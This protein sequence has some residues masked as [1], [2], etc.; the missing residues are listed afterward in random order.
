MQKPLPGISTKK[1]GVWSYMKAHPWLYLLMLPGLIYLIIFNYMPL[2]GIAIAFQNFNFVKG[3][4]GSQWI[5]LKNFQELFRS[6]QFLRV[7]RNSLEFSILRLICTFPMPI[8]LALLLNEVHHTRY[9]KAVQT[10]VYIPHFISWVVVSCLVINLLQPTSDGAV[11]AFLGL[12]GVAPAN[13]LTSPAHF[14]SIV[15][16]AEIWKGA[17][18]GT[19]VYLSAL[20]QLDP[21]IYE[22][23]YIDG[24]NRW[25][26]I[27]RIT[28]PGI[29]STVSVVLILRLGG[30]MNN[31]FEQIYLLY[32]PLVYEVADVF[33]TYTYRIGIQ[34]GRYSY[35]TAVG[36]FK[37]VIGFIL[38][39]CSNA[40]SRKISE[41]SLF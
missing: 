22:A 17:G 39:M 28:L 3:I 1:G 27:R 15:V 14:R 30:L 20:T 32:S 7:F 4:S 29:M 31:G 11:N 9:K 6:A 33:E 25:Q 16:I 34:G 36:L 12:F 23:A 8:L 35:S 21:Q 13:Y 5:G 18:W 24:A 2:Y 37:S 10:I 40:I 41:S 19:I 26:V 38:I